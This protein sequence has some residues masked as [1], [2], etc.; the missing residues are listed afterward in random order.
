MIL[1]SSNNNSVIQ[2][3]M[4]EGKSSVIVPLVATSLANKS[5][6]ARVVV[7][8]AL[9]AQMFQLLTDRL[10]GLAQRRIVYFPFSRRVDVSR[11]QAEIMHRLFVDAMH[12]GAVLVAQPEH[13]LSLSL[14]SVDHLLDG[15][16]RTTVSDLQTLVSNRARDIIDESDEVFHP[17][18]ALVYT[19]GHQ[20]P[21]EGHSLRWHIAQHLLVQ[22]AFN[23]F[24]LRSSA[25]NQLFVQPRGPGTFPI[26][27]ILP[28]A[29]DIGTELVSMIVGDIC[30][31][32]FPF[33]N[34]MHFHP[35]VIRDVASFISNK[36]VDQ[37]VASSIV[38]QFSGDVIWPI[39]LMLR[40]FLACGI[41]TYCLKERRWRVDFGLDAQRSLLAVPYRA[42]DTPTLRSEFGHPDVAIILT[43]LS[44][45]YDGLTVKQLA[46]CF[47]SLFRMDNPALEYAMWIRGLNV[48]PS[49]QDVRGIN[50]DDPIQ[51][52][53]ELFPLFRYTHS[54]INFYLSTFV[55]P[56]AA[57]QFPYK[58]PASGWDLSGVGGE[59]K[60]GFSGTNDNRY[61]L[62]TPITQNDPV[63]QESTN[64]LVLQY[65][66]QPE[67]ASYGC[68]PLEAG[69]QKFLQFLMEVEPHICV[70]LDVG[71][72]M[73]DMRNDELIKAWLMIKPDVGAGVYFNDQDEL[74]VMKRDE[75]I[76]PF[77]SSQYREQ[78][79]KCVI[80]LDDSHTRGT[81][82]KLPRMAKAAVTLG[83][84]VTKDRL[85]QGMPLIMD[86]SEACLIIL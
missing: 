46:L 50:I 12:S 38:A 29:Q 72:Q 76:E 7:L 21:L 74:T 62:P 10:S 58:L 55:F 15:N 24:R 36:E 11:P 28:G 26:I 27:S 25:A 85:V 3:N 61:L 41:L 78:L 42:K 4:G 67:N 86:V 30:Q 44:H 14:M 71:A 51:R 65:L 20:L 8:K 80:Y 66:L 6:L 23:V 73:L 63:N 1:P 48:P 59:L 17:R 45:Y 31:G 60:T 49:L 40:G 32:H 13:I 5:K 69:V 43:C 64:A 56:K 39:L 16:L 84:K 75:T 53:K 54:V 47:D 79:D 70:L 18:Y 52:E 83:K 68:I 33:L 35:I 22:A 82:L 19:R 2:L 9:S 77:V 34:L 37:R 57:K 81:D